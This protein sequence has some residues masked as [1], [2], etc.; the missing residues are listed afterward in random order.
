MKLQEEK[1]LDF[2]KK[3]EDNNEYLIGDLLL[4]SLGITGIVKHYC[5]NNTDVCSLGVFVPTN[6][7]DKF[8]D[9]DNMIPT[10]ISFIKSFIDSNQI[11][12]TN[13]ESERTSFGTINYMPIMGN[14]YR[15]ENPTT[16]YASHLS[17]CDWE[18][19]C[20]HYVI[21]ETC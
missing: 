15:Y 5:Y 4:D 14:K 3:N 7:T 20:G 18:V 13:G 2:L 11:C 8:Q 10:F 1:I 19:L 16:E 6:S 21:N 17:Y 12:L 9:I